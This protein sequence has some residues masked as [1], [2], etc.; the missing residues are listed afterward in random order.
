MTGTNYLNGGVVQVDNLAELASGPLDMNGGTL[1]YTGTDTSNSR[2]VV[3]RGL[4]PTFDIVGGTTFTQSG[5]ITGSGAAIGDLGGITK[6]G[7][8]TLVLAGNNNYNGE[9]I[10]NNGVL[11]INGINSYNATIWDAG[12]VTVNG[13]TL[14]GTGTINGPITVNSGGTITPGNSIGTLTLATNLTMQSGSTNLFEVANLPDPSDLLVVQGDLSVSNSMIAI[15]VPGATLQPGTYTLI[16]YSGKLTGTFNPFNQVIPLAGGSINGSMTIDTSTPGQVNLVLIPQVGITCQPI[17]LFVSTNDTACFNVCATGSAPLSYQWY[18][19]SGGNPIPAD[20][21]GSPAPLDGGSNFVPID[22]ATNSMYCIANCDGSNNGQYYCVVS[23]SY[24]SV[25]SSI[26]SLTV[27]TQCPFMNG[28]LDQTV[29]Q[30]S[31]ATFSVNI[32]LANPYPTLQWQTNGV[33]VNG[34]TNLSLTLYNVQYNALNNATVSLI[35]SNA[36][37]IITNNATLTVIVPPATCTLADIT[38]NA[39]DTAVFHSCFTGG[40]PT[41]GLQWYKKPVGSPGIGVAIPGQ[42]SD[43]L[44]IT[45]AQGSDIAI[46]SIVA[47]NAAGAVTNSAK[48]TVISPIPLPTFLPANNATGVCYDT[49]LYITFNGPV[50]VVNSGKI[51]VYDATNSITPVDVIDMSSNTVIVSTLNT[52]IYLTN[53]VQPHSLFSGDSQVMNYFPVITTGSTAA[54]YPHSGVMTSNHTYYVTMDNGIVVDSSMAYFAGI[55]DTNAWRFTTKSNGPANPT[56]MIVAADGS[57]DFVTV[58]GAVDSVPPGNTNYTVI[59]IRDGNYVEIVDISGKN[60]VTFRGQSRAGTA[61]GYQNNNN[62]TGTT[63]GRMSFKVNSSDTKIE[64]LTLTNATPQGGSQAETLEIYNNGLRCIVDNCDIFGRQDT[65]LINAATS[66]A[67]FHNSKIWGNFDYIWG[68]GVGYFDHCIF[69][70]LTNIYSGS[71][72]LTAARTATSSS[73]STNTPWLNPNGT[74]YSAYGFS[75][76]HCIFEAD[77]GVTN[78]TMAGSN[79]TAGGVDAWIFC[80]IDTNAYVCPAAQLLGQY[81]FWQYMNYDITC[82][83]PI[84][85]PCMQ[86][87]GVTNNDSRLLAATNP[88]VWFYGWSPASMP[89]IIGQPGNQIVS[90]GQSASFTVSA[91]GVP[92]PTYQW[93]HAG[94]NMS[95]GINVMLTIAS[96]KRSDGGNYTVVVS[97]GSGSV[98]SLVATLTYTGNVAPVANP[99]TYSRPAGY[100]LNIPIVGNLATYW[101]DADGDPVAL[102]GAISSTNAAT[103]RYDSSNIYYTNANNLIDQI[104]YTVGDGQATTSGVIIVLVGPPPTNSIAGTA[105]N[106]DGSVTLSFVGVPSYTYLVEAT[107]D[108]TPP[109]VWTPVSTNTA[110]NITGTWQFTDTGAT[111]YTQRFYRSVYR[112]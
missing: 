68:V 92:D 71:Y 105:V 98:T 19:A 54:I 42:T 18:F 106:G 85:F 99:S 66:Q 3:T 27:G 39:G 48:L 2:A 83:N 67:F 13:G 46:Y 15:S 93:Q 14:R 44:T 78:I 73:W 17:S 16:Q 75:F 76:M 88:T 21:G 10:V 70:T 80:C 95:G 5:A 104:N 9:T 64:N 4:G 28:P 37:C 45:N 86:T 60:N 23:N 12:K 102:T 96:A 100:P 108:L 112:P 94:T 91:T 34:A 110:G 74:T 111:N 1:S 47:S 32:I 90:Q 55:S 89:N 57:G 11:A 36:A 103:V 25:T 40:I 97:N 81:V 69:H 26:A 52:G 22:G 51:R 63:A 53:N 59:N 38:V 30:G 79:G 33:N 87:I 84:T 72:N 20:G 41:P 107:L 6:N 8:G 35:A 49:P 7:A 61:I 82:T 65:I 77:P 56:N 101:S 58:Q 109:A 24:N 62:L 29:I 31:N 43:T 50:Y